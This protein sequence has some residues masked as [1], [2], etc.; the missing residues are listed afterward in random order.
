MSLSRRGFH[1][2]DK[3]LS[4]EI[5][6]KLRLMKV[7]DTLYMH[8]KAHTDSLV[9]TRCADSRPDDRVLGVTRNSPWDDLV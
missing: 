6:R 2:D 5:T 1:A 3:S 8:T 4:P 9:L 7:L